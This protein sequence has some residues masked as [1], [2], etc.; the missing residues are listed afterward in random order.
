[1]RLVFRPLRGSRFDKVSVV[2]GVAAVGIPPALSGSVRADWKWLIPMVL[3]V[4]L[5]L[6]VAVLRLYFRL[7]P[8]GGKRRSPAVNTEGRLATIGADDFISG[9]RF[10]ALADLTIATDGILQHRSLPPEAACVVLRGSATG[11]QSMSDADLVRIQKSCRLFVYSS[12]LD[13]FFL[14]IYP[15][16]RGPF[17]LMSHNGD[18]GIGA[19]YRKY[20]DGG[21]IVLWVAQ[22]IEIQ[23]PRL[24]GVPIGIANSQYIH[25]DVEALDRVR[26]ESVAKNRL[27][28]LQ[29]EVQ[30][31]PEERA[32]I[33]KTIQENTDIR[34]Q[35]GRDYE[36][37]LRV[38]ASHRY[39]VCPPGNGVDTHRMW[40]SIYLGV[41]PVVQRSIFTEAFAKLP[42][43]L[44]DDWNQV[45][46]EWLEAHV[47]SSLP[48]S[49][50]RARLSYY[51][52]VLEAA[53][54]VRLGG[55]S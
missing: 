44:V 54:A 38:L 9:E 49:L 14:T 10:Q 23:H 32:R 52:G 45:T 5:L 20:L 12:L 15:R 7:Y 33:L 50:K 21:K 8:T 31:N 6:L 47:V 13:D 30:T 25:G 46:E 48:A 42:M 27:C 1:M 43:L 19:K 36:S 26:R 28:Y 35:P 22:N 37:Y 16:L 34:V 41:V 29:F 3:V 24:I 18:E 39:A 40:E 51:A 53:G 55:V 4:G 2:A 17:V 11:I